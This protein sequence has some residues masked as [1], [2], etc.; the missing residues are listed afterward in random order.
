MDGV[1]A[2]IETQTFG[3]PDGVRAGNGGAE[4]LD[5]REDLFVEIPV[6]VGLEGRGRGNHVAGGKRSFGGGF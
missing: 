3:K 1:F 4:A 2:C 5:W 6:N